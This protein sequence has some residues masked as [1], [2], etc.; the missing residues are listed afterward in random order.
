[1]LLANLYVP[2]AI[3]NKHPIGYR[4]LS[5]LSSVLMHLHTHA[6]SF[7]QLYINLK[8]DYPFHRSFSW[9]HMCDNN[10]ENKKSPQ[11]SPR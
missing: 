3:D 9:S 1:M 5:S 6:S 10:V 4:V 8:K 11:F 2:I 7:E